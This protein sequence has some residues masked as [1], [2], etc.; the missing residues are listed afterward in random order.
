MKFKNC[1]KLLGFVDQESVLKI[2]DIF[3]KGFIFYLKNEESI[4][5]FG[6]FGNDFILI[7][8]GDNK[9]YKYQFNINQ[10]GGLKA[11]KKN[12]YIDIFEIK[13]DLL[14]CCNDY[15]ILHVNDEKI[16]F[17]KDFR[18]CISFH[19]CSLE[20]IK[21]IKT[22]NNQIISKFLKKDD[23]NFSLIILQNQ[24]KNETKE[25][26]NFLDLSPDNT[27]EEYFKDS[28][29]ISLKPTENLDY[30]NDN[31]DI[32]I[33]IKEKEYFKI[34]EININFQNNKNKSLI[35]KRKEVKDEIQ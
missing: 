35:S 25:V 13:Y 2:Y 23:S 12:N 26:K 22:S 10:K 28:S 20:D 18:E 7:N 1:G 30:I 17:F 19:E 32:I 6:F 11:T 9:I 34:S 29:K 14:L 31:E 16:G 8:N 21:Q 24:S 27:K 3:R 5:D 4:I 33:N 15:F